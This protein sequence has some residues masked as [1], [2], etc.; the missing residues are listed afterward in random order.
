[1][2]AI[3]ANNLTLLQ[4]L[5]LPAEAIARITK[6]VQNGET[7]I[8][9][10]SGLTANGTETTAWFN[11]NPATG[12]MVAEGQS[13]EFLGETFEEYLPVISIAL[14][15][16]SFLYITPPEYYQLLKDLLKSLG[17]SIHNAATSPAGVATKGAVSLALITIAGKT[18][19]YPP[20]AVAFLVIG[21]ILG[22]LVAAGDPPLQPEL[23]SL[24]LPFPTQPTDTFNAETNI[25]SNAASG[26]VGGAVQA[27]NAGASG[28][29]TAS[30]SSMANSSFQAIS[31]EAASA[32]VRN[33]HGT[34]IGSG[35][36][37]FTSA[38]AIPLAINGSDSFSVNGTGS[39]SF[40]GSAESSLG[41]SADWDSYSATLTGDASIILTTDGLTLNGQTLPA[42]T[43][44]VTTTAANLGGSG[45]T[46][47]PNFSGS[48]AI[49]AT[50]GTVNLGPGTG[51]VTVGGDPVDPTSGITLDGYT[52]SVTVA[53]G[54]G[55]NLDAVTLNGNTAN[56]L[57]V[58]ATPVALTT[59][60]NT[61][62]T[63]Q[64]NVNTSFADNYN[65]TATAP[66]GW[67]VT[68][69]SAGV[70]TAIPAPGLQGGAYPIQV[71]AQS[72]TNANLVAQTTLEMTIKPATAGE[73]LSV[74]T[75]P[76]F[77]V[78][79]DGAELPTAFKV[80]IDNSGPAPVTENLTFSNVP[81]GFTLVSQRL[82]RH[83]SRRPDRLCRCLPHA[84][85]QP[86]TRHRQLFLHR[87]RHQCDE[88]KG[89]AAR[90]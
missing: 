40:Y 6:N 74:V 32:T 44:T 58:S 70:V 81:S 61:P 88:L 57:T 80:E 30:W 2:T 85:R 45:T 72:S 69:N 83:H 49:T 60:Q 23:M 68:I 25:Q 18:T 67:T 43:Y 56:V 21:A 48:V 33:S 7:V 3:S 51:T 62:K 12:E 66:P 84:E 16:A 31:L 75:D 34:V 22:G 90:H 52:G 55:N 63:L 15:S 46:T 28:N 71:I 19:G 38:N 39:L 1:M 9:P 42:G 76:I 89:R 41:V 64:V 11:Y 35:N 86:D 65:L 36:V 5:N 87:H 27:L 73:T 24:D 26:Q 17:T 37:A 53:A 78:P 82:Q 77:T 54:G 8:V 13:G 50:S 20:F 59:D 4:S 29:M 79:F 10:T 47:S 14:I